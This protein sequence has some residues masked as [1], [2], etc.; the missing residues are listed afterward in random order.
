[1]IG[2]YQD[3]EF[4]VGISLLGVSLLSF[5]STVTT[6]FLIHDMG[7]RNGYLLVLRSLTAMQFFLDIQFFLVPFY[8]VRSIQLLTVFINVFGST[9]VCMWVNFISI[10]LYRIVTNLTSYSV[11]KAYPTAFLTIAVVSTITA[12]AMTAV[13]GMYHG[14]SA[15]FNITNY[16]FLSLRMISIIFNLLVHFKISYRLKEMGFWEANRPKNDPVLILSSRI[17]FYPLVQIFAMLGII[18][19]E[20]QYGFDPSSY[21]NNGSAWR[22]FCLM[23]FGITYPSAGIGYF[24]VF[25][26]FQPNAARHLKHKLEQW[27]S[28]GCCCC[29]CYFA[30]SCRYCSRGSAENES[31]IATSPRSESALS[32]TSGSPIHGRG[33]ESTGLSS[34]RAPSST[35][36]STFS[37]S[38]TAD[39][40][41]EGEED[42]RS[43][44][45][46][47]E[48]QLV[49][50]I[51]QKYPGGSE[52]RGEGTNSSIGLS[53][54]I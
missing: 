5:F 34:S 27:L 47:D 29:C 31:D 48:D 40:L 42:Y 46:L 21:N 32:R 2:P 35:Q 12:S 44:Q 23:F 39:S 37:S 25:L 16:V 36:M 50:A 51:E 10:L 9:A 18:L 4:A 53:Y 33:G 8:Y 43:M 41:L 15:A 54:N 3:L 14:H 49:L 1:M 19:Y 30:R 7:K 20:V 26:L 45:E 11:N 22:S 6:L 17:K 52:S 28:L 24:V 13:T 38:M